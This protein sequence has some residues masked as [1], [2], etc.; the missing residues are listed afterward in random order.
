[1]FYAKSPNGCWRAR[2]VIC[3]LNFQVVVTHPAMN[4]CDEHATVL[5]QQ[6]TLNNYYDTGT[7]IGATGVSV[8]PHLVYYIAKPNLSIRSID[9]YNIIMLNHNRRYR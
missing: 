4:D 3:H 9:R 8:S 2:R 7:L 1:M 6:F 5:H